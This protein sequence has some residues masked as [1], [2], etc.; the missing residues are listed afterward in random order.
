[1]EG[2]ER[3]MRTIYLPAFQKGCVDAGAL[4]IMTAY[5]SYDGIPAVANSRKS[6]HFSGLGP[7]LLTFITP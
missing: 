6:V 5:S 4:A 1:M 2:G 7:F 3:A